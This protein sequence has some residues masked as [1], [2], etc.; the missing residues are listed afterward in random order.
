VYTE[1][2]T[3]LRAVKTDFFFNCWCLE[4]LSDNQKCRVPMGVYNHARKILDWKRS[5]ISMFEVEAAPHSFS[6]ALYMRNLLLE[7]NFD[8]HLCSQCVLVSVIPSSFCFV[9]MYLLSCRDA[10]RDT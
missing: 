3:L 9:N 10:S 2:R 6:I 8:Y 5:R 7:K 1:A 4:I